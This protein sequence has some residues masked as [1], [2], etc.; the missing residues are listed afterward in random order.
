MAVPAPSPHPGRSCHPDAPHQRTSPR[1]RRR[2][3]RRPGSG[4]WR[5]AAAEPRSA[6]RRTARQ[7]RIN[8]STTAP[9]LPCGPGE[10]DRPRPR[11]FPPERPAIRALRRERGRRGRAAPAFAG[12]LLDQAAVVGQRRA[13]VDPVAARRRQRSPHRTGQ[14]PELALRRRPTPGPGLEPGRSAR[15]P[16]PEVRGDRTDHGPQAPAVATL[17]TGGRQVR[18]RC[19]PGVAQRAPAGPG[20]AVHPPLPRDRRTKLSFRSWTRTVQSFGSSPVS[21]GTTR[22]ASRSGRVVRP[23]RTERAGAG[24]IPSSR[25]HP[26]SSASGQVELPVADALEEGPPLAGEELE[27]R[28]LALLLR[29]ADA[30]RAVLGDP[31]L[32]AVVAPAREA[33]LAPTRERA[34]SHG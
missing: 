10:I 6:G 18:P 11:A 15:R 34:L 3:S 2:P 1:S 31:D 30:D 22:S 26:S 7:A 5:P 17:R 24:G 13:L 12:Q 29:V 9:P 23:V 8:V 21:V 14:E 19:S 25:P 33:R 20:H 27:D 4:P 28:A 16:A 32:D